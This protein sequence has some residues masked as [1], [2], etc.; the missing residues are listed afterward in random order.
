MWNAIQND[1]NYIDAYRENQLYFHKDGF[2]F[3]EELA[4]NWNYQQQ[5]DA[6]NHGMNTNWTDP[7]STDIHSLEKIDNI[8]NYITKY[9][10]KSID[11]NFTELY[12]VWRDAG[13]TAKEIDI[14]KWN[15]I[16][17]KYSHLLIDGKLWSCSSN[18]QTL[19][20]YSCPVDSQVEDIVFSTINRDSS[21]EWKNI[22]CSVISNINLNEVK[23]R[24]PVLYNDFIKTT[25]NNYNLL[26]N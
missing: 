20:K 19:V 16:N 2:C 10:T 4:K 6:Y 5:L 14:E 8:A 17:E 11:E 13:L 12:K 25:L 7:N 3:R 9:L 1:N 26:Y 15:V 22:H 18:L 24:S 21:N 23:N